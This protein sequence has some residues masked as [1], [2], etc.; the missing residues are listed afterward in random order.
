MVRAGRAR[1]DFNHPLAGRTL[2]YKYRIVKV[3][4]DRAEKVSTLLETNTGLDGFE[5]SFDGDDVT[6]T[7]PE[8]VGYNQNWAFTKFSIIRTL[9]DHV[10]VETIVFRE[11]HE[12][13]Q[14]DEDA[15]D[16]EDAEGSEEE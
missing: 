10:G 2:R 14:V 3:V 6:I 8:S 13:R 1:I 7:L 4:E 12:A 5:V 11:V 9:R 16:A 15:E